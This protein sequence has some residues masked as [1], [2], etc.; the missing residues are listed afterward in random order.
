MEFKDFQ[1]HPLV[2]AGVKAAGYDEAD[3]MFDMGFLPDI[4]KIIKHVPTK[5]QTLLFSATMPDDDIRRL[6]HDVLH[7]PDRPHRPGC[8]DRRC[9]YFHYP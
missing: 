7:A 3:R 5:R 1:F 8:E 9:L 4:R 2:A 6:A